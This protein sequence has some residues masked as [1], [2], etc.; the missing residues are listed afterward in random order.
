MHHPSWQ[1]NGSLSKESRPA[2]TAA[3]YKVDV[4]KITAQVQAELLEKKSQGRKEVN[5]KAL[6][7]Y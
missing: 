3:R 7:K 2:V 6:A 1:P 5:P 4:A